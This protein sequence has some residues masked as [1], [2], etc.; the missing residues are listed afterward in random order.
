MLFCSTTGTCSYCG[1]K[2]PGRAIADGYL[3]HECAE[4]CSRMLVKIGG[5]DEASFKALPLK[6]AALM[7]RIYARSRIFRPTVTTSSV[8]AKVEFDEDLR[9]WRYPAVLGKYWTFEYTDITSFKQ[10][11]ETAKKRIPGTGASFAGGTIGGEKAAIATG[12][13]GSKSDQV[14]VNYGIEVKV[15]NNHMV[16]VVRIMVIKNGEVGFGSVTHKAAI[17]TV[18]D[19]VHMFHQVTQEPVSVKQKYKTPWKS[20]LADVNCNLIA[21]RQKYIDD[22]ADVFEDRFA[23]WALKGRL[24]SRFN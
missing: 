23:K 22:M 17:S 1:K 2:G 18:N 4:Y 6:N 11:L 13:M 9:L 15:A 24:L 16:P 19:I 5:A 10:I 7:L 20:R 14:V 8:A 3:C 21:R 12:N